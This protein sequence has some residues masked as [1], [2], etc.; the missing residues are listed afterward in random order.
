[1]LFDALL[2]LRAEVLRE[3]GEGAHHCARATRE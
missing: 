1:V 2:A 3:F